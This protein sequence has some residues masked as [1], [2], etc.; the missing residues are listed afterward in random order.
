[1]PGNNMPGNNMPGNH[2]PR[3]PRP[4]DVDDD[5]GNRLPQGKRNDAA[6]H[7]ANVRS[8]ANSPPKDDDVGNRATRESQRPRPTGNEGPRPERPADADDNFGNR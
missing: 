8:D 5:I 4:A 6:R 7:D 1:M 2:T 3:L